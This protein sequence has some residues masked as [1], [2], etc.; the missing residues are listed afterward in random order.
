MEGTI[1][2]YNK[3]NEQMEQGNVSQESEGACPFNHESEGLPQDLENIIRNDAIGNTMYSKSWLLKFILKL[4]NTRSVE[5]YH[6]HFCEESRIEQGTGNGIY[7]FR[8]LWCRT[9]GMPGM[10][11]YR[12]VVMTH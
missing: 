2:Q 1:M 3:S 7:C 6:S 8:C 10:A 11:H 12:E 5:N 4:A 9:D